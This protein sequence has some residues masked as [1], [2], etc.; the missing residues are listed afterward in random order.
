MNVENNINNNVTIANVPVHYVNSYLYLEI[1]IDRHFTFKPYFT[2]MLKKISYK[3][4]LLLRIGF[5]I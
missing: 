3:L 4:S 1:D 5:M 2:N